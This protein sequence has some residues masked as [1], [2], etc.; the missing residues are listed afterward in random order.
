MTCPIPGRVAG[1]TSTEGHVI[2]GESV[3]LSCDPGYLVSGAAIVECLANGTLDKPLGDCVFGKLKMR[4]KNG[5]YMLKFKIIFSHKS[6]SDNSSITCQSPKISGGYPSSWGLVPANT[7][8]TV[9]CHPGY[10][11]TGH[12][13]ITCLGGNQWDKVPGTCVRKECGVT[14]PF[15]GNDEIDDQES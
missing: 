15:S 14:V 10:H 3:I 8:L 5:N 11:V 4:I 6:L 7:T 9:T 13:T 2:P 1:V 12:V